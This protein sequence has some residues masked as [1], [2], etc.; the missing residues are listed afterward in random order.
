MAGYVYGASEAATFKARVEYEI[1]ELLRE[2]D[3]LRKQ[4]AAQ[5][6]LAKRLQKQ[7]L[8]IVDP[9][10]AEPEITQHGGYVGLLAA[11]AEISEYD[12]T[13]AR[14]DGLGHTYYTGT[15]VEDEVRGL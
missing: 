3:R 6:R 12:R 2:S 11:D 14:R 10:S 5:R 13:K 8:S 9:Q 1:S 4:I 15:R 7:N